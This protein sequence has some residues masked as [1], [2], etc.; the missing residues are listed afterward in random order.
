MAH[1]R[2]PEDLFKVQRELFAKYHVT[3]AEGVLQRAGLL[4]DPGRPDQGPTAGEPQPPYYLTLKMP[5]QAEPSFSLT[6]TFVPNNRAQPRRLHG[7]GLRTRAPTTARSGC[8]SCPGTRN[9]PGPGQVQNNFES[10]PTISSAADAAAQ[11]RVDGDVRQPAVAAGRPADCST[12]SRSTCARPPAPTY[13]LLRKV[14][15]AFGNDRRWATPRATRWTR[16]STA[17]SGTTPTTDRRRRHRH[18]RT[19]DRRR[20]R[21]SSRPLWRTRRAALDAPGRGAEGRATSRPTARRRRTWPPRSR[22]AVRLAGGDPEHRR[23]RRRP[24]ATTSPSPSPSGSAAS[25]DGSG[26]GPGFAR[27][28]PG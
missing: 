9:V 8:S 3:D 5:G 18:R 7:R 10:D 23:R 17:T 15:V 1:L 6:T 22:C 21:R 11:R 14:L 20:T 19:R 27:C 4:A 12:S 13:P 16:C 28:G 26:G 2:Y 25:A 24:G